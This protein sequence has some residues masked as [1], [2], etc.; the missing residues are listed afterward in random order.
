MSIKKYLLA[1]CAATSMAAAQQ[2]QTTPYELIRPVFPLT[3]DS[4]V[5]KDFDTTVAIIHQILPKKLTP[6]EYEP[7]AIVPDS[8]NQAYFDAMNVRI[9]PIRVN[10]AGYLES[11]PER[12]FY[13]VGD[14]TTFEVVDINGKSFSPAITGTLR[15]SNSKTS[16]EWTIL[17]GTNATT[18]DQQR[19]K[20]T[21]HGPSGT[22]MIGNIPQNVPVETRL[23]IKVGDDISSTFI[24]SENV[25]SMV[26]DAALKFYG[27]NRSG[28]SETWFRNRPASHTKD[29]GGPV[30]EGPLDV[31]GPYNAALAGTLEGGYYDCGDHLKESHTQMYAFMVMALMAAANDSTDTD[32]Y[33]FNQNETSQRR[34]RRHGAFDRIKRLRPWLVGPPTE[35]GSLT[36]RKLERR[37]RPR[38]SPS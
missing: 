10:Q 17:A 1:L 31:R 38:R 6:P 7:N 8:L 2:A 27:I 33:A 11:D 25:Y 20:V 9:S 15:S 21:T 18:G 37:Q 5:F 26:K 35:P 28:H 30:T 34:H 4:T 19:Y 24:I 16:S 29:G 3:W 13:Y 22:I 14:K 23:R 12:Q 36:Y 32:H